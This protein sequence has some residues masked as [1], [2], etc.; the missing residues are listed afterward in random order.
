MTWLEKVKEKVT[1]QKQRFEEVQRFLKK[2]EIE[3]VDAGKLLTLGSA[4]GKI[5]NEPV[6]LTTFSL[7]NEPFIGLEAEV[8]VEGLE[9]KIR[10]G[11]RLIGGE[12]RLKSY[13]GKPAEKAIT[14]FSDQAKMMANAMAEVFNKFT[15]V[16]QTLEND[17][18]IGETLAVFVGDGDIIEVAR[19]TVEAKS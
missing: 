3:G 14:V 2:F 4:E 5:S 16:I 12:I 9:I 6:R 19:N 18:V 10:S 1:T 7:P 17:K 8:C 15:Q 11:Y 13:R